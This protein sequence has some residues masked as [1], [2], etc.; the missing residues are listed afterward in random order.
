VAELQIG[1]IAI[2]N[3]CGNR[4]CR[5]LPRTLPHPSTSRN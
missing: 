5:R 3:S 1:A 4:P 2:S